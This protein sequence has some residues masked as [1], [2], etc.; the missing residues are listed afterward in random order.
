MAFDFSDNTSAGV[1]LQ[2]QLEELDDYQSN[3]PENRL[4]NR[5]SNLIVAVDLYRDDL[6]A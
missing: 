3:R 2:L 4:E 5:L 1:A 6:A